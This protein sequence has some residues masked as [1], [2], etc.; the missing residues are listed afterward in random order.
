MLGCQEDFRGPHGL[1]DQMVSGGYEST[2]GNG[3]GALD[4]MTWYRFSLCEFC[5]DWLFSQFKVPVKTGCYT[6]NDLPGEEEVWRPAAQRVTED[7]W[8]GM[9]EAFQFEHDRHVAARKK[10]VDGKS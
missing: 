5:L 8:R 2:P 4:D 1:V 3:H 7:E 6:S 9:K 10:D